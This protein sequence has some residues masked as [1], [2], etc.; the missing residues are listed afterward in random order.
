VHIM[1]RL[2]DVLLVAAVVV[3]MAVQASIGFG[4]G[5]FVAPAAFAAFRPEQAVTLLLLLALLINVL[6]LYAERRTARVHRRE[7]ATLCVWA[8]PGIVAGAL[9]VREVD[10]NVL[11][12][13]IG[14][15]VV[16]VAGLQ[17]RHPPS[18]GESRPRAAGGRS[19]TLA[20]GGLGSGV[21]TTATSLNGPAV[22]LTLTR[23]G[24][25]GHLLRDSAAAAFIV[26][27]VAGTLAL[28]LLA[29]TGHSLPRRPFLLALLPAV[30]AGHR[31]GAELFRRLNAERHRRLV[32]AAAMA[33]GTVSIVAGLV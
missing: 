11:Q 17:A 3:G 20:A 33:A 6:V 21:L 19:A 27:A 15:V 22:V 28:A 30:V 7:V 32:L 10:P 8:V 1:A 13:V 29:G 5:F 16:A 2:L 4:F 26:L 14:A 9:V 24:L 12:V 25:R 18:H 31:L 23:A